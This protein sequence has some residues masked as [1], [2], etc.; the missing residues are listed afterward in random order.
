[1]M[2]FINSPLV[3]AYASEYHTG[4]VDELAYIEPEWVKVLTLGNKPPSGTPNGDLFRWRVRRDRSDATLMSKAYGNEGRY[5]RRWIIEVFNTD[6]VVA[7]KINAAINP[8]T[9]FA[10]MVKR[11]GSTQTMETYS[12]MFPGVGDIAATAL[13]EPL[14]DLLLPYCCQDPSS[15]IVGS[16]LFIAFAGKIESRRADSNR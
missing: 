2:E 5:K 1:M 15:I 12:H 14:A 11:R 13:E 7:S 4:I 10:P 3:V 8:T 9:F 6:V 16:S